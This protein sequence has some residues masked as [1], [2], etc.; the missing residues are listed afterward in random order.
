MSMGRRVNLKGVFVYKP[1]DKYIP[2][3]S[4]ET[5]YYVYIKYLDGTEEDVGF[6]HNKDKRDEF[7]RMLD[8]NLL[9]ADE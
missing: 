4:K 3:I 6:V 5:Y 8:E 2:L 1:Y 9:N 7:L